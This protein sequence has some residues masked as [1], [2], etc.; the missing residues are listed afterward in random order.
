[1]PDYRRAW[2]PGGT[3]FFTVNALVRHNNDLFVRHI[4]A[5]R[6]AVAKV[7][8]RFPFV[9]HGWVVL[10]DHMHCMI[11]L[12]PGDMDSAT[13]WR[14]IKMIF[15]KSLPVTEYRSTVRKQRGERGLWQRRY[16]ENLIRDDKDFAAHLDCIHINPVKHGL[17]TRVRD[18]PYSTFHR[19]VL[20]GVYAENWAGDIGND[21]L[22]YDD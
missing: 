14:Q 9:I 21:T 17:V 7:K 1:M 13:R 19:L 11:E 5:L 20:N 3:Y 16:W 2:H 8:R 18:W 10:P 12:P 6:L 4:N 15:S 22:P